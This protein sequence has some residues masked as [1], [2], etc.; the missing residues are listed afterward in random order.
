MSAARPCLFIQSH[1]AVD[2]STKAHDPI[3]RAGSDE[4][5]RRPENS[6]SLANAGSG[7]VDEGCWALMLACRG[8]FETRPY[9]SPRAQPGTTLFVTLHMIAIGPDRR[10]VRCATRIC[11]SSSIAET[12]C[13][14]PG[15]VLEQANEDAC[16]RLLHTSMATAITHGRYTPVKFGPPW[17]HTC[18]ASPIA[19]R[20]APV[21]N[22]A[23]RKPQ[24]HPPRRAPG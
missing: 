20:R 22:P 8:G 15:Q 4:I 14:T 13:G 1:I 10:L 16:G 6:R 19:P 24:P 5:M 9:M 18:R 3:L 11:F 2:D 17:R 23:L 21:A 12:L 7:G